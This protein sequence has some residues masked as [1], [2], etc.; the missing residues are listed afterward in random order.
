MAW[1]GVWVEWQREAEGKAVTCNAAYGIG[2]CCVATLRPRKTIYLLKNYVYFLSVRRVHFHLVCN[3][4]A[5][6]VSSICG[7]ATSYELF[8]SAFPPP[9]SAA[10]QSLV[11]CFYAAVVAAPFLDRLRG[12]TDGLMIAETYLA[13]APPAIAVDRSGGSEEA[14]RRRAEN[15][16]SPIIQVGSFICNRALI[17]WSRAMPCEL[18]SANKLI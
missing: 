14:R 6:S 11:Y 13:L 17:S 8:P 4:I 15:E 18:C 2:H 16:I 7:W 10:T 3:V 12:Q 9:I 5:F 1:P